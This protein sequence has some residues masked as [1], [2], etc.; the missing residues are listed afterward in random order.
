M[1]TFT[2]SVWDRLIEINDLRAAGLVRGMIALLPEGDG[3]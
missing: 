1:G 3:S 2:S